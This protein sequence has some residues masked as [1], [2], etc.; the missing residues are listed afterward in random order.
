VSDAVVFLVPGSFQISSDRPSIE[1]RV[2]LAPN[3]WV[4]QLPR[5]QSEAI[6]EACEPRGFQYDPTRLYVELY[7]F[8]RENPPSNP[9]CSW[10][11]DNILKR[12]IALSRL[13]HPTSVCF[14]HTATVTTDQAGQI[15]SIAPGIVDG[16]GSGAA[17]AQ[18]ECDWL[19]P[20]DADSLRELL[21]VYRP[22]LLPKRVETAF[23]YHEY[24]AWS[25]ELNVR[26]V[27]VVT[28]LEALVHT[29]WVP[30]TAQFTTRIPLLANEVG[31][32]SVTTDEA[33]QMYNVR[34]SFAHGENLASL[35]EEYR[36]LYY[37][38]ESLLRRTVDRA[39]FDRE[40]AAVFSD[41]ATINKRWPVQ[42][43]KPTRHAA[44]SRRK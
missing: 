43:G 6:I 40:F 24:A 7:T 21:A 22:D 38:M 42:S 41:E 27:L 13:I 11:A 16:S 36:G 8:I 10:D 30:S 37:K 19:T 39:I 5:K 29:P 1:E 33:G 2:N 12:C 3:L 15:V 20:S 35:D 4:G 31:V 17:V 18:P 9:S 26:W 32:P 25:Y 34:S 14:R 44:S 23:W 28:G